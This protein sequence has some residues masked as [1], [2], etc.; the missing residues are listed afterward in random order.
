MTSKLN[1]HDLLVGI[2]SGDLKAFDHFYERHAPGLYLYLVSLMRNPES[3]T[4]IL[5]DF[6]ILLLNKLEQFIAADRIKEYLL[7]TAR[8]LTLN[9]ISKGKSY[10]EHLKRFGEQGRA[11][12]MTSSALEPAEALALTEAIVRLSGEK[13]EIVILHL[14]NGLSFQEIKAVLGGHAK[15][16]YRRYQQALQDLKR[17]LQDSHNG[18]D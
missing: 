14:Y 4:D 8:N 10:R 13:R 15:A 9:E 18:A 6:F 16:H 11:L 12:P 5:Q 1:D 2:Q 7:K 3:A 17:L